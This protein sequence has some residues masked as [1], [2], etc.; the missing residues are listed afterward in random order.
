MGILAF[1]VLVGRA[2]FEQECKQTTCDL[3]CYGDF[4]MPCFLSANAKDFIAKALC[5][6][7]ASRPT[8]RELLAHPWV[9]VEASRS[10]APS[11]N[12]SFLRQASIDS[13]NADGL[14]TRRQAAKGS[15]L[16][17]DTP[18]ASEERACQ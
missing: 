8:I 1:E 17:P 4:V 6:K 16:Q 15:M 3:I 18:P 14:G 7:A 9:S 2:P 12:S 5:K 13:F 11:I 10:S